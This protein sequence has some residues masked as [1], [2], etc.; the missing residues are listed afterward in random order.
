MCSATKTINRRGAFTLIELL[1]VISIILVIAALAAAFAPRMSDSTNLSRSVDQ[2]EQWLL[3]AKMRAR[4]RPVGDWPSF[5]AGPGRSRRNMFSV[6]V[7]PAAG[8]AVGRLDVYDRLERRHPSNGGRRYGDVRQCRFHDGWRAPAQSVSGA[9]GRLPGSP[10]RRRFSDWG[11]DGAGF[12]PTRHR[13]RQH[14]QHQHAHDELSHSP[15]AAHPDR[16]SAAP[17]AEQLRGRSRPSAATSSKPPWAI[18]ISCSRPRA[19][20][21]ARTR[22][23]ARC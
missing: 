20:W 1:V 3:T 9:A 18:S 23:A 8:P 5:R 17:V 11:C 6:P 12:D 16:G 13:L 4:A 19:R 14:A 15:P 10:R 22:A 21:S 7:H 2:L